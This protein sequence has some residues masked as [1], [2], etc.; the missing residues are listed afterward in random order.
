MESTPSPLMNLIVKRR[1]IRS[2]SDKPV[3][4]EKITAILEAAR[5]APSAC[6]SQCWR[7]IVVQDEEK[8]RA[9]TKKGMGGIVPNRWAR[10]APVIIVACADLTLF[11]HKIGG[12]L[13]GIEYHMLD[14]GCAV[15]HLVLRATE[16]DLGTCWIGW[17]KEKAIREILHIPE[18]VRIVS[19][20]SLGYALKENNRK[21][22]RR[23]L[24]E[25]AYLDRYDKK[26]PWMEP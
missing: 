4:E 25:I 13:K 16:L 9:I 7:F 17:F 14:L 1:S 26:S 23:A 21:K 3:E 11:T 24:K 12:G 22:K 2:Y 5:L 19:L 20:I 10:K 18:K 8:R 15:E 6:N